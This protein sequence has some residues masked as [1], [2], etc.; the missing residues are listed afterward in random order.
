MLNI[1]IS[2]N[3]LGE[4]NWTLQR[5]GPL[6]KLEQPAISMQPA[7][8]L[9]AMRRRSDLVIATKSNVYQHAQFERYFTHPQAFFVPFHA[10]LVV[11]W[12]IDR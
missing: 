8:P 1:Q 7:V 10:T 3:R 12:S 2:A 4:I 5:L 6:L 11:H 9:L